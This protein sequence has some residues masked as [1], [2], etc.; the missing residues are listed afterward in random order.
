[1][2]DNVVELPKPSEEDLPKMPEA[3]E[4]SLHDPG[5][6]AAAILVSEIAMQIFGGQA[7]V[8]AIPDPEGWHQKQAG[9]QNDHPGIFVE[10]TSMAVQ[11]LTASMVVPFEITSF[12]ELRRVFANMMVQLKEAEERKAHQ[13][14][15]LVPEKKLLIPR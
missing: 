1:M 2:A 8:N 14:T 4:A 7:M 6:V 12:G 15:L 13:N 11:G 5:W 3:T 10:V 9:M